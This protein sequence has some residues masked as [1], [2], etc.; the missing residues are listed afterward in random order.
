VD[1]AL[2][3]PQLCQAIA[4]SKKGKIKTEPSIQRI[5]GKKHEGSDRKVI[6]GNLEGDISG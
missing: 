5:G 1:N 2:R 4:L 6:F 3:Y